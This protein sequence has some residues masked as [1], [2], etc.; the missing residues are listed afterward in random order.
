MITATWLVVSL[1]QQRITHMEN[2]FVIKVTIKGSEKKNVRIA[3]NKGFL[4]LGQTEC[5]GQRESFLISFISRL[6]GELQ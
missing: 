5:R 2:H 3:Y 1:K 4:Q 6:T